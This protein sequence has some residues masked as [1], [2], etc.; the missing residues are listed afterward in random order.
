MNVYYIP[1]NNQTDKQSVAHIRQNPWEKLLE[2]KL[3]IQGVI[4]IP[5][6]HTK[7]AVERFQQDQ[8]IE[9]DD[10]KAIANLPIGSMVFIPDGSVKGGVLTTI[11]S[12]VRAGIIDHLCIARKERNCG[13]LFTMGSRECMECK[14]SVVEVFETTNQ[15]EWWGGGV[16]ANTS[17]KLREHLAA[18]RIIEPF[19][20]L[21]RVCTANNDLVNLKDYD[22]RSYATCS[23]FAKKNIYWERVVEQRVIPQGF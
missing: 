3:N 8:H 15:N 16:N 11:Q 22:M 5:H 9:G 19:Y 21:Y 12:E 7:D 13:H 10:A 14:E 20:S 23:S 1:T 2:N 4:H 18:G 17:T 6:C